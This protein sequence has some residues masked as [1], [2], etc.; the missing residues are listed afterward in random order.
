[1]GLASDYLHRNDRAG[2]YPQ[3]YY[4]AT[5]QALPEQPTWAGDGTADVCIVGAGYTGLSA[6]LHLATRGYDVVVV[7]AHR[8]GWGASGRNGGQL[9]SGQRVEQDVLEGRHG[10]AVADALWNLGQSAKQLTKSIIARH[11]IECDLTPGVMHAD[12]RARFVDDSRAYVELLN[13]RYNYP[14]ASFID[15]DAMRDM[16]GSKGYHG[17]ILDSDA[18]HLHPLN[19][20]LGLAR[21]AQRAGARLFERSEVLH[22]DAGSSPVV[23]LTNGCINARHLILACNGYL[24]VLSRPVAARVMPIN[25]YII[26]TEP[27]DE[28]TARSLIRD[29]VAVADSRFVVNY[30]R[31]SVDRRLLF[32]GGESYSSKFPAD[33]RAFVQ[34]PMLEVYPQL[35]DT[36]ID[37]GWGGTLGI[38]W[39]RMPYFTRLG[40]TTYS[41]GGYSGHGVAMATLAGEILAETIDGQASRFDVFATLP[42]PRFPGGSLL[43]WPLLAT[44][45]L[46][47]ALL[48]RL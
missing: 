23:R 20:A 29:D 19:Y 16:V 45:M 6:A 37:Y 9:G 44:G 13:T 41:A 42:T 22:I 25:N 18:A 43:R 27:L 35:A 30:F 28:A 8:V 36:R 26:A 46:Y 4:A 3:S 15:R 14:H 38:T 24:E 40:P 48:D 12:H 2:E 1:M 7:D 17:G 10:A 47:Y 34:K 21:A 32:G 33:I 31:L 11:G 5:M 39:K